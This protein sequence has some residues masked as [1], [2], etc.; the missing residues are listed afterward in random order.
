MSRDFEVDCCV[1]FIMVLTAAQ[2]AAFF[3]NQMLV[4]A[5]TRLQM[6]N[7][8]MSAVQ[9]LLEC[10]ENML[11]SLEDRLRKPGQGVAPLTSTFL[12]S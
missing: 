12:G 11:D 8:G 4:P 2:Q 7:E 9:D 10:N 5:A 1:L 6:V 3:A